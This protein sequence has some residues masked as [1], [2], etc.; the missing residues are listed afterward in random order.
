MLDDIYYLDNLL[1]EGKNRE[2]INIEVIDI[3]TINIEMI[4]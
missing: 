2:I 1:V 4:A 3:E